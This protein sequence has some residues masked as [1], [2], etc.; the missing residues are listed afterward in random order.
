MIAFVIAG[1]I[2]TQPLMATGNELGV[3]FVRDTEPGTL[4]PKH[5]LCYLFDQE[6]YQVVLPL[7]KRPT[8]LA[9]HDQTLWFVGD[10]QHPVLYRARLIENQETGEMRTVPNGKAIAV[11]SLPIVG[12]IREIVFL[13]NE[14]IVVVEH[15]G[16]HCFGIDGVAITPKLVGEGWHIAVLRD[17]LVAAK[18]DEANTI[19]CIFEDGAWEETGSYNIEG[20]VHD[21]IVHD[22]WPILVTTKNNAIQIV[23]LQQNESVSIA[24]FPNLTGRWAVIVGGGLHAIG[25]ER[26]GTITAFDIGWPSGTTSERIVLVE[27]HG[28]IKAVE[29]VLLIAT[30]CMFFIMMLSIL[31]SKPKKSNKL[32]S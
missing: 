5:E 31:K 24:S 12:E 25:A 32:D 19:V 21:F 3:W 29:M 30:T 13:N 18:S 23:G 10:S 22:S 20:K 14:P 17:G 7:S 16:M 11:T 8:A 4:G 26:N 27:Q 9:I 1:I 6:K 28:S 2:A 15:E